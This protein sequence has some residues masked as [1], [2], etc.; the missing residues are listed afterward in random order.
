M[1][2]VA[3]ALAPAPRSF[4]FV[5]PPGALQ[6]G[7]AIPIARINYQLSAQ[8]ITAKVMGNTTSISVTCTLPANFVYTFE[9]MTVDLEVID[10][11]A[12]ADNFDNVGDLTFSSGDGLGVRRT[13][14]LSDGSGGTTLNAG[15]AKQW[16]ANNPGVAPIFNQLQNQPNVTININDRDSAATNAA[17]FNFV[18]SMLQFDFD[19]AFSYAL[20]FPLPV[21]IR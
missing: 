4:P 8:V 20:N 14:I 13:S 18:L 11:I 9:Y 17:V 15:S 7:S 2:N 16:K 3:F 1:A 10:D 5:T 21:S 12:E 6:R 19:Q